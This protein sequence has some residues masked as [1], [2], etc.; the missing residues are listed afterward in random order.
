VSPGEQGSPS[1]YDVPGDYSSAIPLLA[2]CGIA[3]GQVELAGLAWPSADPDAAAVAVLERMGLEIRTGASGIHARCSGP[4]PAAVR[5]RATDFP[6]AVPPLAALAAF[7]RTESRFDGV[8]H[9][10][11]KESDRIEALARLLA[12][13]GVGSAAEPD[14]LRVSGAPATARS[15][16]TR[17]PTFGDHRIAMAAGLLALRIP[18]VLIENPGCVAKSYPEFFRDLETIVVR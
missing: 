1:C 3:G 9:L 6:D 13:A 2:A 17:L 10:K 16:L 14:A 11:E 15:G 12:A 8:A 5:V 7:A 18:G 4:A